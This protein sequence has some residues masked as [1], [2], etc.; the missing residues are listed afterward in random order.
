MNKHRYN[1]A[2]SD[3][4]DNPDYEIE[5]VF[6]PDSLEWVAEEAAEQYHSDHDGWESSWPL[7]FTIYQ[8]GKRLRAFEVHQD[9]KPVF[10]AADHRG[11][12]ND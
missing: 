3:T 2:V 11:Q 10:I 6:G 5:S 9:V 1:Y 7:V 4:G 8:D 12:S